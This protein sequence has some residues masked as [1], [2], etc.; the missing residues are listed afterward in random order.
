MRASS[1]RREQRERREQPEHRDCVSR[2]NACSINTHSFTLFTPLYNARARRDLPYRD[3]D[4]SALA[5]VL[6]G[7]KKGAPPAITPLP[8]GIEEPTESAGIRIR[9]GTGARG[10]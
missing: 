9:A 8:Q 1:E 7:H 5:R 2:A 3:N 4:S 6:S 10:D